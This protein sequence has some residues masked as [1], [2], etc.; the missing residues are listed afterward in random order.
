MNGL[1]LSRQ[2]NTAVLITFQNNIARVCVITARCTILQ[3]EVLRLHVVRPSVTLV[4]QDYIR[5]KTWKLIAW[6]I[7]LTSSLFL[8]QRPSI[9]SQGNMGKFWGD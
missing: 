5:W 2:M 6:T 9:Y 4:D 1:L 7:S 8:A 3:N